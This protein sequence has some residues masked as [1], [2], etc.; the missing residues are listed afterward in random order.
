[1]KSIPAMT[2]LVSAVALAAAT[3]EGIAMTVRRQ[4]YDWK[5]YFASLGSAI[6]RRATRTLLQAGPFGFA[7]ALLEL[8][9]RHRLFNIPLGSAALLALLL[10]G[11]ELCY[12]WYH[13]MSHR[14]R[15]FWATHVV[16]HSPSDLNLA[17]AYQLGWTG[18][19][20]GTLFFFVPLVWLGFPPRAVL[21]TLAVNLLYQFWLHTRWIPRL[22]PLEWLLNTPSHH[23]VHHACNPEYLGPEHLGANYGGILILFDRL[24][25]TFVAERDDIP[26]RYGLVKPLASYNPFYIAFHEWIAMTR[27]L[28]CARSWRERAQYLFNRPGW[29]PVGSNGR[30]PLPS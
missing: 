6:G 27:D 24:F 11:E 12:Y 8:A 4:R 2:L 18:E 26:C 19:L 23:R 7:T 28:L 20:T 25:G 29:A 1:M 14:V 15:W 9:W 17:V 16:H 13:R 10:L 30:K 21:T 3:A 22:G 5:A